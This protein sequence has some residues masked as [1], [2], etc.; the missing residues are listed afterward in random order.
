MADVGIV[1]WASVRDSDVVQG[2]RQEALTVADMMTVDAVTIPGTGYRRTSNERCVDNTLETRIGEVISHIVLEGFIVFITDLNK[3]FCYPTTSPMPSVDI[4][5]PIELTSIYTTS[6]SRPFKVRDVQ[7]AY[8]RFAIFTHEGTVLT[9]SSDLLRLVQKASGKTSEGI[10]QTLAAPAIVHSPQTRPIISIAFGDHHFHALHNNGTITAYGSEP[11]GCGALGLGDSI[12]KLRGVRD[13]GV[14]RDK[15]LDEGEGRTVWFEPLMATWLSDIQDKRYSVGESR[16]RGMMSDV[17]HDGAR[18]A[19]ADY[20]EREGAKW[21]GDMI[22]EHEMGAYFVLKVAAAGWSSAALV[23]VD[24]EKAKKVREA[25]TVLHRRSSSP[26]PS[27]Q[28][29]D[30]YEV[31]DSPA[32]QLTN[33]IYA[34]YEWVWGLGRSFL[35]LTARDNRRESESKGEAEVE[36]AWTKE[37]FPRL[38]LAD[39][40][41]MPGEIPLTE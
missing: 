32:E 39:G 13:Y 6:L 4:P 16:E 18:K 35:G 26:A 28:T 14:S 12:S 11:A 24:E 8:S 17:G 34:V 25:Q 21:E 5:E 22:E 3:I 23:I 7:G 31:I 37:P 19:Y 10:S 2:G 9:A 36:Y 41:P 27:A 30:S 40:T 29:D 20:F 15:R 38:R 33:A 1:Y